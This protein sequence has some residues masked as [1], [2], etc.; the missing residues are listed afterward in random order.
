MT[1]EEVINGTATKE[2]LVEFI[3]NAGDDMNNIANRIN[4][5]VWYEDWSKIEAISEEIEKYWFSERTE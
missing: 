2:E 1:Y 4:E 3:K 5:A